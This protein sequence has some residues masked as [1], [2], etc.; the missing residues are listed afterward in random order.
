V[1]EEE[2]I[3][4]VSSVSEKKMKKVSTPFGCSSASSS[5]Q[6]TSLVSSP[7][8]ISSA[9]GSRVLLDPNGL[10]EEDE[11]LVLELEMAAKK[12]IS[13]RVD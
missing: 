4:K 1:E 5:L 8:A 12:L 2:V 9:G 10:L 13:M 11:R 3:E 6:S 7:T